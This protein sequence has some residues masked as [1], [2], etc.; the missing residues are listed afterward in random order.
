MG[1]GALFLISIFVA[2]GQSKGVSSVVRVLRTEFGTSFIRR[3]SP[4]IL[5]GYIFVKMVK[6]G[7][8]LDYCVGFW[9]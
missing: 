5:Y 1:G 9:V 3:F 6:Q 2:I 4:R 8:F 7:H